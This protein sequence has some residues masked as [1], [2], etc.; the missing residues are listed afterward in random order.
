M[1]YMIHKFHNAPLPHPRLWICMFELCIL[2]YGTGAFRGLWDC[3]NFAIFRAIISSELLMYPCMKQARILYDTLQ[4]SATEPNTT[5]YI[6][7]CYVSLF[8]KKYAY[9]ICRC[10]WKRRHKLDIPTWFVLFLF[11]ALSHDKPTGIIHT[12]MW[13]I[14]CFFCLII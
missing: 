11:R 2:D 7:Y 8:R 12:R 13:A 6:D 4:R 14:V 3:S 9:F 5:Y 10:N 1:L